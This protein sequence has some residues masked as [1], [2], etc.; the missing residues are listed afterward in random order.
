MNFEHIYRPGRLPPPL[1]ER[2][3]HKTRAVTAHPVI[4]LYVSLILFLL[5]HTGSGEA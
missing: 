3:P 5:A 2:L 4:I 1:P